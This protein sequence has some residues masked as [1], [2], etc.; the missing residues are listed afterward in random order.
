[1]TQVSGV[2]INLPTKDVAASRAFYEALGFTINTDFSNEKATCVVLGTGMFAMILHEDFFQTFTPNKISNAKEQTEVLN[3]IDLGSREAT[4][5]ILVKA[6]AAGGTEP[7]EVQDLGFM[8][9][10]AFTDLD[11]HI[12]EAFHM[13]MSQMPQE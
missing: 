6:L 3:A 8:Y 9:S 13:D 7:R 12:W 5:E 4:D 10:R 1:M 11:G 2:F